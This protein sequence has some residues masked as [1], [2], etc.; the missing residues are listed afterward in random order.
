[1]VIKESSD[2][3]NP[4]QVAAAAATPHRP[5]ISFKD[6]LALAIA[7]CGVGYLPWAPGTWGSLVGIGLYLL[8][9]YLVFH[10]YVAPLVGGA[11]VFESTLFPIFVFQCILL[12]FVVGISVVGAWAATQ[13][14]RITGRKDASIVVIDEVAGQLLTFFIV[15]DYLAPGW[16][17]LGFILFRVF[18]IVKPFPARRVE[19]M[20]GGIGVVGDDLIAGV[21]GTWALAAAMVVGSLI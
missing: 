2:E 15:L 18:D 12:L 13:A 21:Y 4:P 7:T 8:L 3:L 20:A 10:P 16:I 1:M 11:G 14:E 19:A 17:I 9:R 6:K 5:T